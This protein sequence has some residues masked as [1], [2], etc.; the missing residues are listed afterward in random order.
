[1]SNVAIP[2][3]ILTSKKLA[4]WMA[5][6]TKNIK[7]KVKIF[8]EKE[9]NKEPLHKL[10]FILKKQLN[11]DI[12]ADKFADIYAQAIVYGLFST[13]IAQEYG[14][15]I[16]NILKIIPDTDFLIKN[17]F[18]DS[19]L[20]KLGIN[21]LNELLKKNN[22]E[23]IIHEF[24]KNRNVEDPI[25][26]F[27]ELFLKEYAPKQRFGKGV[28][29]TPEPVVSFIVR[30]VDYLL[31]TEF[32]CPDG[33]TDSTIKHHQFKK[34]IRQAPKIQILDPATGTGTFLKGVIERIKKT[35]DK[36]HERL[37]K[38][39]LE[40]NWNDYVSNDLLPRIFGFELML[41][42]YM[43]AHLKLGLKLSETGYNFKSNGN[44]RIYLA[45]ALEN[46]Q[47]YN[48]IFESSIIIGNPPYSGFPSNKGK[49]ITDLVRDYYYVDG[50][51][52]EE[53]NPKWLLDD[54]VKF[55][56]F[57][58]WCINRAGFGILAFITNH[59]YLDNPTFR[60]M[61]ENLMNDFPIIYICNLHGNS[62]KKEISPD[63]SKDE[64]VFDI[65]QGVCIGF[66]IKPL[67]K[68]SQKRIFHVDVWGSREDKFNWLKNQN[69]DTINW[70]TL[71][72][73]SPFYLFVPQQKDL[74]KEYQTG[75]KLTDIFK[76]YSAGIATA[77]DH[78]TIQWNKDELLNILNDFVKLSPE[79]A[80]KKYNL[81]KDVRDW[82]VKFAQKDVVDTN[83][84]PN[85][86]IPILYRP[87][88]IRYT[89]YTGRSRG[90]LCMPRPEVMKNMLLDNNIGIS[91]SR[92]VRGAPWRDAFASKFITEFG[93][94]ATRPGNTAPLFPLYIY[95]K[96][97]KKI[98]QKL[99]LSNEAISKFSKKLGLNFVDKG[100]YDIKNTLTPEKIFHYIYA[101]LYSQKFRNRYAEFLKIDFPYIPMTKNIELFKQLAILG[102]DLVAFHTLNENYNEASWNQNNLNSPFLENL[103]HF[104]NGNNGKQMGKF[105][106][107]C[108]KNGKIFIDS[109]RKKNGS[110]FINIPEDV[111]NF[112]IG[113]YQ[114]CYKWLYNKSVKG[115]VEGKI[116]TKKDIQ[117][118]KKIV[119]AIK[120]T[121]QI[122]KKID[123]IIEEY[124]D[125]P[126]K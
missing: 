117:N 40:E 70:N 95:E 80:R 56:R 120:Q 61:R 94:I 17:L 79:E 62:I 65:K 31:R 78:F 41:I 59:G 97:E 42:P 121:I 90:F 16:A 64:C 99:N 44:L 125:W 4:F 109:N 6:L 36:K 81:R 5:H 35:F 111:W 54:Y 46:I 37:N 119:I 48:E 20:K 8:F 73:I 12:T 87:F 18:N 103:V 15:S 91:V 63:G 100:N 71:S 104:V 49:W 126:I 7:E 114:V 26:H 21:E 77:R 29:Y 25:I 89:Y 108:Y 76:I 84:N 82:K 1:M 57:G 118:F 14:F 112:Y 9:N 13:R 106:R 28:F 30:S 68:V 72:P 122:M 45:N 55:I 43:V 67:S 96:R 47:D 123:E 69:I 83:I 116:L 23:N 11:E 22:I 34:N 93:L 98:L 33:L 85:L 110:Y 105:N 86:I 51:R 24:R 60:G 3:K 2:E 32:N 92:S 53:K 113:S 50:K 10:F 27:Y 58:Q 115:K 102:A 107:D 38:E 74:W 88:D 52:L 19:N 39:V 66:F 75:I 101:I 124:G